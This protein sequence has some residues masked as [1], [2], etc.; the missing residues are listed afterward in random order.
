MWTLAVH[1]IVA[2]ELLNG[3]PIAINGESADVRACIGN[4]K[5]A[6]S[7]ECFHAD[8]CVYNLSKASTV[9]NMGQ[10]AMALCSLH[11]FNSRLP[12]Y[13]SFTQGQRQ[14]RCPLKLYVF[15]YVISI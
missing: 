2:R 3:V 6:C 1:N 7:E 10:S 4:L 11:Q 9:Y 12:R 14:V 15:C 13:M 5:V 8:F